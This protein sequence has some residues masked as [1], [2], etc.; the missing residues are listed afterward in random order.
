[1]CVLEEGGL[2]R[3]NGERDTR[4]GERCMSEWLLSSLHVR[5]KKDELTWWVALCAY[6]MWLTWKTERRKTESA[7][8]R[9]KYPDRI[10]VIVEKV[11]KSDIPDID[12]KKYVMTRHDTQRKA[13]DARLETGFR[14]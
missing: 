9:E 2:E 14:T 13:K 10:P 3:G 12:K 11:E 6:D 4:K 8:I 1:M 5:R 7:R